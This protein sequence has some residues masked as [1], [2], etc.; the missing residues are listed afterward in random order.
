[1][2]EIDFKSFPITRY[3]GSKRRI[4]PWIHE[5]VKDLRFNTALDAFGGTGSVSYLF[6]KMGK[7][8]TYNDKLRFNYIIGKTLIQNSRTKLLPED[9]ENLFQW[10]EEN[11][12]E[13]FIENTFGGVY[14]YRKENRWLDGMNSGILNMNHYHG[15]VLDYKKSI[16]YYALFQACMIKRPFNL[17]HRKNLNI[18]H[19]E[20]GVTRNFGNKT[21]WSKPFIQHFEKF[22]LEANNSIFSSGVPCTAINKSV[23]DIK[24]TDFDL[25]YLDPPYITKQNYKNE[26]ANYLKCYHFLEGLAKYQTWPNLI[27]FESNN[28]TF[29][30][31]KSENDFTIENAYDKFEELISKFRDSIIV[32]SYKSGG[33]PSVAKIVSIMQKYKK[34]V[35]AE[36]RHLKYALNRTNGANKEYLIIG[37]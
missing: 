20:A 36:G 21:T 32:F 10:I 3:Q 5:S 28:L 7:E 24:K 18:R 8:V 22:V 4:L 6:K 16:A 37:K 17:F 23:F 15:K 12:S 2:Q 13:N 30:K 31:G 27:D 1:M 19:R 35:T 25:V 33:E 11:P 29:K 9:L 26:T 14:Y 34:N